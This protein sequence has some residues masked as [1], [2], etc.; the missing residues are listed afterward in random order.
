MAPWTVSRPFT[1]TFNSR[2]STVRGRSACRSATATSWLV[3]R[4]CVLAAPETTNAVGDMRLH[5]VTDYADARM[6][7]RVTMRGGGSETHDADGRSQP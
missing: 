1:L 5:G 6:H 7:S 3:A 4:F 2:I